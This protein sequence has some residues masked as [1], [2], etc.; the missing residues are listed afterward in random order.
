MKRSEDE[1][2]GSANSCSEHLPCSLSLTI[3]F[4]TDLNVNALK[5]LVKFYTMNFISLV[6]HAHKPNL[7]S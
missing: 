4:N 7:I 1:G 6:I 3:F 2:G 5:E